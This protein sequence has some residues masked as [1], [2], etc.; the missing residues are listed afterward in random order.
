MHLVEIDHV[1]SE[2]AQRGMQGAG[3]MSSGQATGVRSGSARKSTLRGEHHRLG[4]VARAAGEPASDDLLRSTGR[5]DVRSIDQRPA[6]FGKAIELG[7]RNGLIGFGAERHRAEAQVGHG[8]TAVTESAVLHDS[9]T[10]PGGLPHAS[11]AL[12]LRGD[13]G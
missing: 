10:Y 13:V 12:H 11:S 4:D 9:A 3:Q 7:V 6:C 1:D 2:T 8:A 5:V